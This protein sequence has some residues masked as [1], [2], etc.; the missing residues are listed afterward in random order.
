[1]I[2]GLA[3]SIR[4]AGSAGRGAFFKLV[5]LGPWAYTRAGSK[6]ERTIVKVVIRIIDS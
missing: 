3:P 1:M 4:P 6:E 5:G 2:M